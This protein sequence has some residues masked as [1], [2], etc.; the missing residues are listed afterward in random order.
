MKVNW[1]LV[2]LIS[3]MFVLSVGATN[4]VSTPAVIN[5]GALFSFNSTIGEVVK[6]AIQ[7]AVNDVN[8]NSSILHGSTL[9]LT[10][11]NS[12]CSGFM[13]FIQGI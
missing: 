13:G 12:D 8:S 5:I 3:L 9:N 2:L 11:R 1:L 10:M 4:N 7:E 6:I